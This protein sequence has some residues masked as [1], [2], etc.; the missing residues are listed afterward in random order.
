MNRAKLKE[1]IIADEGMVKHIY[2]DHLGYPTFGVGHLITEKDPEWKKPLGT[3]VSEERIRECL[4]KDLDTVLKDC[5]I[6][7]PDFDDLPEEVQ[8]IVANMMFNMG[9][10]RLS[11]FKGM[12]KG[13]DSKDWNKAADEMVDSRWYKQVTNRANRL[14]ERMRKVNV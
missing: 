10:P 8:H 2:E 14:V 11:A 4:E 1:E 3:E 7:Y 5:K 6:L 13:V 12:K 9:R